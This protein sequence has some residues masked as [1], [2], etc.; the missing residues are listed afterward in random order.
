[1][2]AHMR[3]ELEM[4][5]IGQS[6]FRRNR[7][8]AEPQGIGSQDKGETISLGSPFRIQ[9][10][11]DFTAFLAEDRGFVHCHVL[12]SAVPVISITVFSVTRS[13]IAADAASIGAKSA[14][15]SPTRA[16]YGELVRVEEAAA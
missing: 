1:M 12:N 3:P 5:E 14:M 13:E 2:Q 11:H 8:Q 7:R 9:G 15:H 10:Q 6:S 16:G 4:L